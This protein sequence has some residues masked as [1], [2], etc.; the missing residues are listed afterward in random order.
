M[1]SSIEKHLDAR[2]HKKKKSCQ[3]HVRFSCA[4]K[5][6]M[7]MKVEPI[8]LRTYAIHA[9]YRKVSSFV[10]PRPPLW[11]PD[12]QTIKLCIFKASLIALQRAQTQSRPNP[13][14]F[15]E[16]T[17]PV[18]AILKIWLIQNIFLRSPEPLLE[19]QF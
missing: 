17:K 1:M 14:Q 4:G 6:E 5:C 19:K 15:H 2:G 9:Q 13:E 7:M 8:Y 3:F 12:I 16:Y 11:P 18:S 10:P